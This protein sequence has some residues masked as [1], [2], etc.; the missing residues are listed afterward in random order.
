MKELYKDPSVGSGVPRELG[1]GLNCSAS[2][3]A[4]DVNLI[5]QLPLAPPPPELPP[6]P[7]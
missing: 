2:L 7:E 6:P 5:Y 3:Y 4:Y 1:D